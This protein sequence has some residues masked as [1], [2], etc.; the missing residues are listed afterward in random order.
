MLLKRRRSVLWM[1]AALL[2]TFAGC[3]EYV[4]ISTPA[5]APGQLVELSINDRGRV[6]LSDRF[7][8]G[9]AAVEARMLSE[10][11]NELT[12]NVYRVTQISGESTQ[13]NGETAR[14]DRSFVETVKGRKI[15]TTRTMIAVAA[16]VAAVAF[17]VYNRNLLGSWAG[18]DQTEPSGPPPASVRIPAIP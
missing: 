2:P 13:W 12:L 3:Y 14:L 7:G 1:L 8:A 15:S 9:L 11:G 17:L 6:A 5:P 4:P 16:G 18:S 10:Q